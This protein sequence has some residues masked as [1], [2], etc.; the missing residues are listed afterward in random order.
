MPMA[1]LSPP[2]Q[3]RWS[4]DR[5][6]C[7]QTLPLT[8]SGALW[9]PIEEEPDD[10][11]DQRESCADK[12][13]LSPSVRERHPGNYRRGYNSA[14]TGTAVE[15]RHSKRALAHRKPLGNRFC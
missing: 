6:E 11:H 5:T 13:C 10:H 1:A 14:D 7:V 8:G 4:V 2:A 3:H 15:D 9:N 12:E